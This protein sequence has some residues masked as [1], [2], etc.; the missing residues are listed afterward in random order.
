M[1]SS[2]KPPSITRPWQLELKKRNKPGWK[3]RDNVRARSSIA[4]D[5]GT[6]SGLCRKKKLERVLSR[7]GFSIL[8]NIW[9][10]RSRSAADLFVLPSATIVSPVPT[11]DH[12]KHTRDR[13]ITPST[14]LTIHNTTVVPDF[15][16]KPWLVSHLSAP[17]SVLTFG[18]SRC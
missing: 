12:L 10:E 6:T 1:S 13:L 8:C 15:D 16:S 2:R 3:R 18:F 7:K 9:S 11:L 17:S 14:S 4:S 5:M